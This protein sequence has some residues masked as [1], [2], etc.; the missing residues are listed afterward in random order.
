MYE[1]F[2]SIYRLLLVNDG[3]S[4]IHLNLNLEISMQDRRTDLAHTS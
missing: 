4:Y 2:L 3:E 1:N